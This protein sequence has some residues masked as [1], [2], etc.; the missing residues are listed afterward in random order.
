[1]AVDVAAFR[2]AGWERTSYLCMACLLTYEYCELT[3]WLM[4]LYWLY[5]WQL[6]NLAV[7]WVPWLRTV[8]VFL[9]TNLL[10]KVEY[11]WVRNSLTRTTP[12]L[13]ER[14]YRS[15]NAGLLE[16]VYSSG[17]VP[18][19]FTILSSSH[20]MENRVDIIVLYLTCQFSLTFSV[21]AG[22]YI[23]TFLF[24]ANAVGKN[25][26]ATFGFQFVTVDPSF[27]APSTF[28]RSGCAF[29]L[30]LDCMA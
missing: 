22:G 28:N 13:T 14:S 27:R 6:F 17:F 23:W 16:N 12:R 19:R 5:E 10:F 18:V 25:P 1:M 15:K 26:S 11:F 2:Q 29:S 7:K 30:L 20:R 8:S 4:S 9:E 21:S 24:S 3:I